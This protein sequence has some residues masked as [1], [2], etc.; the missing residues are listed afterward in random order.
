MESFEVGLPVL[1]LALALRLVRDVLGLV[2]TFLAHLT[3]KLV[4]PRRCAPEAHQREG[5][6]RQLPLSFYLTSILVAAQGRFRSLRRKLHYQASAESS[7]VGTHLTHKL[8][9]PRRRAPE[10]HQRGGYSRRLPLSFY[11]TSILVAARGR[12]RSLRRTLHYQASAESS[13]VGTNPPGET[14]PLSEFSRWRNLFF[15][16][17]GCL[18]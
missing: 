11:H 6:S 1:S 15:E 3:H 16:S 10:A 5:Y 7:C 9:S 12:F 14:I 17:E 8:V 18:T 13:C 4:S 2:S